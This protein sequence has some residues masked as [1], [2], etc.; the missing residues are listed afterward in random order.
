VL[1]RLDER[2]LDLQSKP[3]LPTP[4]LELEEST[5]AVTTETLD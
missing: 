1:F 5:R 4:E 3:P 2:L